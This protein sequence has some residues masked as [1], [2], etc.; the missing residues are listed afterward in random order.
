[1]KGLEKRG[2][3]SGTEKKREG[4]ASGGQRERE[5]ETKILCEKSNGHQPIN[6]LLLKRAEQLQ[7]VKE[8]LL[9]RR[10]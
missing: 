6:R 8:T 1:M 5:R 7:E 10:G 3:V 2:G 9:R 4:G